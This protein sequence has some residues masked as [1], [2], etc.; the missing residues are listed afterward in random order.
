MVSA[1]SAS[2][3]SL[4]TSERGRPASGGGPVVRLRA[5]TASPEVAVTLAVSH[6]DP[7]HL[8]ACAESTD[9]SRIVSF[10]R[11]LDRVETVERIEPGA[12]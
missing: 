10:D 1:I 9:V 4:P 5:R 11:S 7:S 12:D 6:C 3:R 2:S 8:V